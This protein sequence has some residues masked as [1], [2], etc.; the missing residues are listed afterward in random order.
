[1]SDLV[2]HGSALG[3]FITYAVRRTDPMSQMQVCTFYV[4][5][6]PDLYARDVG[7]TIAVEVVP[8][9]GEEVCLMYRRET[10]FFRVLR[11]RHVMHVDDDLA[12]LNSCEVYCEVITIDGERLA[13]G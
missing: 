9:V 13:H 12:H 1:M 7:Y 5:D 2:L 8:R 6:A 10:L 3:C 11:L 4:P